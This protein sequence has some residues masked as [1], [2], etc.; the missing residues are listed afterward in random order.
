MSDEVFPAISVDTNKKFFVCIFTVLSRN[1]TQ[2][3]ITFSDI[4][5][6]KMEKT[7]NLLNEDRQR[8]ATFERMLSKEP[9]LG[10]ELYKIWFGTLLN[11]SSLEKQFTAELEFNYERLR[12]YSL[13][14]QVQ[15]VPNG[16]TD[17]LSYSNIAPPPINSGG[18]VTPQ[19]PSQQQYS[20]QSQF[21]QR[22]QPQTPQQYPP[23]QSQQYPPSQSQQY[24]PSQSQQYPP[25]QSQQRPVIPGPPRPFVTGVFRPS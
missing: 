3:V 17:I 16:Y 22:S 8:E 5:T 10:K 2:P 1:L 20:P 15:G 7:F 4:I 21:T 9:T 13:G 24:P 18:A 14:A 25:S 19:R 12:A 6:S 11:L 23:S